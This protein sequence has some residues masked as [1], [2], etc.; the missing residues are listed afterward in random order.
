MDKL[1]ELSSF[2]NEFLYD[3]SK[4]TSK[5]SPEI[6]QPGQHYKTVQQYMYTAL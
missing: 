1:I 5:P 2:L 3:D 4:D 6:T